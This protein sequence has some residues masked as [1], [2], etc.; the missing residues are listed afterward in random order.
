MRDV[1]TFLLIVCLLEVAKILR[2]RSLAGY[3]GRLD[4]GAY[5]S[6]RLM[7]AV[8]TREVSKQVSSTFPASEVS[9]ARAKIEVSERIWGLCER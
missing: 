4:L 7:S 3:G 5:A 8:R 9:I 1:Q 6:F 2:G